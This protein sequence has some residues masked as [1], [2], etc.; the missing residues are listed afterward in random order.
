LT[1]PR[2]RITDKVNPKSG[3]KTVSPVRF[4]GT[5]QAVR[6]RLT[7]TKFEE[8]TTPKCHGHILVLEGTR[9]IGDDRPESGNFTVA[10]GVAT[11]RD[12]QIT[13]GD[14]L[15]GN[16]HLVPETAHDTHADLYRVGTLQTSGICKN[17][18][19]AATVTVIRLTDPRNFRDAT[20]RHIPACLYASD[21]PYFPITRK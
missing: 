13:P 1:P 2:Q 19:Y 10:I 6:P 11:Q 9:T 12:K 17:C 5:V 16:A 14:L 18:P 15:S 8:E 7:L 4:W 20:Y 21:C 3:V